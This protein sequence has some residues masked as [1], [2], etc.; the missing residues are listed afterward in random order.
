MLFKKG[1]IAI[2]KALKDLREMLCQELEEIARKGELSAGSLETVH[3][4]TDTVKNIDKICMLEEGGYSEDGDPVAM[5]SYDSYRSYGNG[6]YRGG[7]YSDRSYAGASYR[8]GRNNSGGSY[9]RAEGQDMIKE[10]ISKMMRNSDM[11]GAEKGV[12][13]RAMQILEEH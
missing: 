2:M 7:S 5:G 12:L 10:H 13:Q 4:L 8:M 3:K 9:S 1:V 11:S 6:S